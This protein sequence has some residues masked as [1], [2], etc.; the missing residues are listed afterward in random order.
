VLLAANCCGLQRRTDVANRR[1]RAVELSG[2]SDFNRVRDHY[3]SRER[4]RSHK[5]DYGKMHTYTKRD[6]S[7]P[8]KARSLIMERF[9]RFQAK[10]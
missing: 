9:V 3:A 7:D 2:F 10:G 5:L 6:M 8:L 1:Q 4:F